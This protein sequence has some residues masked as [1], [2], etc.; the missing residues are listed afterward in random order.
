MGKPL[1]TS[2]RSSS[3]DAKC[4]AT[5]TVA[6]QPLHTGAERCVIQQAETLGIGLEIAA[7][8]AARHEGRVIC[9]MVEIA[10]TGHDPARVGVHA[11]PDGAGGGAGAPLAA[12]RVASVEDCRLEAFGLEKA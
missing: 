1:A 4:I 10:K 11:G 5:V 8:L 3:G 6:C 2:C 7:D 12:N 9:F